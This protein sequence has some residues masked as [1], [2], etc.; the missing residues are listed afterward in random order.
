MTHPYQIHPTA[1]SQELRDFFKRDSYNHINLSDCPSKQKWPPHSSVD[2]DTRRFEFSPI[3][4]SKSSWDFCKKREWDSISMMW[5]MTFQASDLKG[6]KFLEFLDDDSKPLEPSTIKGGPWLQYFGQSNCLCAR[7]TR[8]IVNHAPIGEYRLRFFPMEEFACPCGV[9]P[10]GLRHHILYE[11]KRF[12]NYW[13]LRRDSIGH[14][15]Q[16]LILNG[17]AFSFKDSI[18]SSNH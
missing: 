16:F 8:A 7:A 10:I 11:C 15:S 5:K 3:L 9:Y 6:K 13:N 17:S 1:I 14:F 12:N 18:V 2:K 4:P